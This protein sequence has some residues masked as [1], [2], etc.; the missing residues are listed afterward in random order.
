M[1]TWTLT[2]EQPNNRAQRTSGEVAG[3][4]EAAAALVTAAHEY[5]QHISV[6]TRCTLDI[7][8]EVIAMLVSSDGDGHP[9]R[10]AALE[11]LER[12]NLVE[13]VNSQTVD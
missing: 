3:R 11:L 5:I 7:D 1:T 4:A 9:D 12:I 13:N 8:G 2:T 10:A 6:P